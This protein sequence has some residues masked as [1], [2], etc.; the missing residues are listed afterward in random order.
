MWYGVHVVWWYVVWWYV[1]WCP[2]GMVSMWYGGM[3]AVVHRSLLDQLV[4]HVKANHPYDTPEV[5]ALPVLGG[6]PA[7]LQWLADSTAHGSKE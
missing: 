4:T 3:C 2:C 5:L 6:S 7:Y 1:V